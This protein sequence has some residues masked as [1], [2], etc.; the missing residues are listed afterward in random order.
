MRW[1]IFTLWASEP[2]DAG[3]DFEQLIEMQFPSGATAF[4]QTIHFQM[5]NDFH[6]VIAH[7]N[8]FPVSEAGQ[9]V[10][11]VS[12]KTQAGVFNE[13]QRLPFAVSH[14]P[15]ESIGKPAE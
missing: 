15:I 7:V 11:I 6:R 5:E 8:T 9:Y 4:R 13:L 1:A 10:L 2:D 3:H 12:I 14:H